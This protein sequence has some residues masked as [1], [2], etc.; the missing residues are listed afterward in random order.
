M[1]TVKLGS[2]GLGKLGY[3]HAKNIALGIRNAELFAVCD[4]S[5]DALHRA[6][7]ELGVKHTYTSYDEMLENKELDGIVIVSPSAFH[8]DHIKKAVNKNLPIFLR[9]TVGT[10]FRRGLSNK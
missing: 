9:K 2:I 5:E 6:K 10:K 8:F 1:K 7:T 4:Q 3:L